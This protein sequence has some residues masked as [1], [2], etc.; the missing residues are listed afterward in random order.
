MVKF[1]NAETTK[2]NCQELFTQ[3]IKMYKICGSVKLKVLCGIKSF[4]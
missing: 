1:D 3:K 4:L 2:Y